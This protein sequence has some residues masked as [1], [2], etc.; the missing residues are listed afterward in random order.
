MNVQ[1]IITIS[2]IFLLIVH[3]A[4]TSYTS[5]IGSVYAQ[6][7]AISSIFP[8]LNISETVR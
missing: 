7:P 8:V 6:V 5:L 3:L 1:S 4:S 2:G